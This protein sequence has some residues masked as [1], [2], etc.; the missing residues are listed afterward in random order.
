MGAEES[1]DTHQLVAPG[2]HASSAKSLHSNSLED[3]AG[4]RDGEASC[5]SRI[6]VPIPNIESESREKKGCEPGLI[7]GRTLG[8]CGPVIL[9]RLLEVLPF[10]SQTTGK[11]DRCS[12]FPLPTSRSLLLSEGFSLSDDEVSWV[13]AVCVSLNSY[14]GSTLLCDGRRNDAQMRSVRMIVEEVHRFCKIS[15]RCDVLDWST[16]FSVRSIDYRGEEVR[17]ARYFSWDN[18]SPALPREIGVVPLQEVCQYGARHYVENFD[19]YLKPP[20]EWVP[21]SRPRV[22]VREEHWDAVCLGLLDAGV[23]TLLEASEVFETPDGLLL[24]GLFGVP[25]DETTSL[26]VDIYR[27]IMNLV[28]STACAGRSLETWTPSRHGVAW[29]LFSF[30]LKRTYL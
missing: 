14:W 28:H 23:C 30:S 6:D 24:N 21:P 12:L 19:L 8:Q 18:V 2:L 16:F 22:M 1:G 26:G 29:R 27:L 10:C 9:Q 4:D 3:P 17:V 11:D 13:L 5:F 7:E 15:E 20:N 25:K